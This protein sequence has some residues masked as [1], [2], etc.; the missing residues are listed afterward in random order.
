[1]KSSPI[2]TV[3][4]WQ[5]SVLHDY[6]KICQ[7]KGI[8]R[9]LINPLLNWNSMQVWSTTLLNQQNPQP[10]IF[11]IYLNNFSAER[12]CILGATPVKGTLGYEL[13][14][15]SFSIKRNGLSWC[16]CDSGCLLAP[17]DLSHPSDV[18]LSKLSKQCYHKEKNIEEQQEDTI[19]P[20]QVEAL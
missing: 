19:G 7:P 15:S 5:R 13:I 11:V 3:N 9:N 16:F 1:M 14:T 12:A 8:E 10:H 17:S 20:S 18:E 4:H 2:W 6:L